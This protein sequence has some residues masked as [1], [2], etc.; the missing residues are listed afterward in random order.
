MTLATVPETKPAQSR[1][2]RWQ[3]AA[4][5]A[6]GVGIQL[7]GAAII[8]GSLPV[9]LG[10]R[11]WQVVRA[12]Q[13]LPLIS[14]PTLLN[15]LIL[16]ILGQGIRE[17]RRAAYLL[18]LILQIPTLAVDI[19]I[20]F[21]AAR[22]ATIPPVPGHRG[23][24]IFLEMLTAFLLILALVL[25]RGVFTMRLPRTALASGVSVLAGG[26]AVS[27]ALG[28]TLIW[29]FPGAVGVGRDRVI[30]A[31]HATVGTVPSGILL[32][33]PWS[34]PP[35]WT[36]HTVNLVSSLALLVALI[37]FIGASRRQ[38]TMTPDDELGIRRLL[39]TSRTADSLGYFGTR[40]EKTIAFAPDR[41]AAVSY[42]VF[43]GVALAS[44]DP[45]GAQ[46]DWPAAIAAWRRDCERNGWSTAVLGV[47]EDGAQA[48]RAAGFRVSR[49]G[50]EAVLTTDT[51]DLDDQR[52]GSVRRSLRRLRRAGYR[53]DVRRQADVASARLA[54]LAAC[55]DDWRHGSRERG[56][57]MAL[58]RLGDPSDPD[59]VVACSS[60][61]DGR[62]VAL[63][64]FV[65]WGRD[66]LSLDLMR[67]SP[68]ADNGAVDATI[69]TVAAWGKQAGIDRISLNFAMF[70]D[71]LERGEHVAA[72]PAE[73]FDRQ[74]ILLLSRWWQI[75]S[76]LEANEKFAPTWMRRYQC[77][78][79]GLS[80][81]R[82][83]I[84]AGIAEGFL[85][86]MWRRARSRR[87]QERPASFAH[88]VA[89]QERR[90]ATAQRAA[91]VDSARIDQGARWRHLDALPAR[92]AP[93]H[94]LPTGWPAPVSCTEATERLASS[95]QRDLVV[96]GRLVSIR[97]HGGVV[98]ATLR[99]EGEDLQLMFERAVAADYVSVRL[100]DPGDTVLVE[101]RPGTSRR[102]APAVQVGRWTV[103]AKCLTAFPRG[104]RPGPRDDRWV[105]LSLLPQDRRALLARSAVLRALR[106]RLHA[107]RFAEVETPM[108][109]QVQ[110]GASARPFRTQL[111][112]THQPLTL[113]IAPELA[114]K[115]LVA[116][117]LNRIF[118]LGRDFRNEGLDRV[119]SPEFTVLEAYAAGEDVT[120]MRALAERL[121]TAAA[122]AV[123][124]EASIVDRAGARIPV[125][126][127]W[128][129]R[130][131]L[132]ALSDATGIHLTARTS[133]AELAR[134]CAQS[135]LPAAPADDADTLIDRLYSHLVEAQT[136]SPTFYVGFPAS[137][138]P[139]AAVD[140]EHPELAARWDLVAG[141]MEI[142]TGYTELTD[143]VEQRRRLAVQAWQAQHGDPEAMEY[144]GDFVRA[145]E[146]GLPPLG[147]LGLGVDRIVMLLT[148]RD[149]RGTLAETLADTARV[150]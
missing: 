13:P 133:P 26:L 4:A 118:E 49:L 71:R 115:R 74:V 136:V 135:G 31:L 6:I 25:L 85:P 107:E 41:Q 99:S 148:G 27:A 39:L 101:G 56:F 21:F 150:R 12:I 130:T 87:R 68:D 36:L 69:A 83:A 14:T 149:I 91:A 1:R 138:T 62:L 47:T 33:E 8:I 114:L 94:R 89:A 76:L 120:G 43:Q 17:R 63:L 15:G 58:S 119:H 110:G 70:R 16:V 140:P 123:H 52:V 9:L 32:R 77:V 81:I 38:Q 75:A 59:L 37:V 90:I 65:P 139:L 132:D 55:A 100:L 80:L 121:V 73:R 126:T 50:D 97:R 34:R 86:D 2:T 48:Y 67:R 7:V 144:D 35:V 145:L 82:V 112:A 109:L 103:L 61:A 134:L 72:T 108:L 96:W 10:D 20:A 5:V 19:W 88:R 22:P 141:G 142:G 84:A 124:G 102:G 28:I 53:F 79:P 51:F 117:G 143:P 57:S 122:V 42:A 116:G 92:L 29:L 11:F 66:G 95:D 98:F 137:G 45:L 131:V 44:G 18:V 64:T 54:E 93:T 30:W 60:D 46:A 111:N 129:V 127:P 125:P 146:Y 3:V 128:P 106:E 40:R 147:G 23:E 24:R 78:Q 105:R 113:R 104:G